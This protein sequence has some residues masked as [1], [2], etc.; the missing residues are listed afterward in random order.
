MN[1]E[2][3]T[4]LLV[5]TPVETSIEQMYYR[6][7]LD[8]G[9]SQVDL[10]DIAA[11]LKPWMKGRT[12]TRLMP[13]LRNTE[14]SKTLSAHL[15]RSRD[16]YKLIFLFKGMQFSRRVLE[17][18]RKLAPSAIWININPDNPWNKVSK[19]ATNANVLESL[20]FFDSYCIWSHSVAEKLRK[21]GCN[22]VIYLPFGYDAKY[23]VKNKALLPNS[24][25]GI[26]FIG[27][28]D[29]EREYLLTQLSDI[30]VDVNIYGNNWNRASR[31]F[32]FRKDI[33]HGPVFGSVMSAIMSS[34]AISLNLLREQNAGSHNM[35]T[36]ETPAM[37][38]LMLT[39]RTEEQHEFFPENEACYMY[40]DIRELKEKIEYIIRN[41]QEAKKVRDRG[42]ELVTNHTYSNRVQTLMQELGR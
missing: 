13:R 21:N 34:S 6:A 28:W 3:T 23:H 10:L 30:N 12:I 37:G 2:M 25:N 32:P 20:T 16:K 41:R 14:A 5:G 11:T 22:K 4:V 36:F 39:A 27:S 17:E 24:G 1:S 33:F 9:Y 15:R 18:C 35:R 7:F 42:I 31:S 8:N 19:G 29:K 26:S 40:G 38:G